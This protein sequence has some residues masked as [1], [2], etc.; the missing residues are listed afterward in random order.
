MSGSEKAG[1]LLDQLTAKH[2]SRSL[3]D[4]FAEESEQRRVAASVAEMTTSEL[5]RIRLHQ[6]VQR[7]TQLIALQAPP[8]VLVTE[9]M[10]VQETAEG[11]FPDDVAL[12]LVQRM[13]A[14]A[15]ERLGRCIHDTCE[16]S[17]STNQQ[18]F[19]YCAEHFKEI[20]AGES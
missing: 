4:Q 5:L 19:G 8:V 13:K 2:A 6:R 20:E 15:K 18:H 10:M 12:V 7:L 16:K 3:A 11:A 9:I 17:A 14:K 1:S